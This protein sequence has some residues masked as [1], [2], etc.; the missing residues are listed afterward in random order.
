MDKRIIVISGGSQGLGEAMTKTLCG[1]NHT[2]IILARHEETLKQAKASHGCDYRVCDVSDA[3]QC[4]DAVS[5]IIEAYGRI[6]VLINNAG[7]VMKGELEKASS[8]DIE[9]IL[10]VNTLGTMYLTQAVIPHM[11]KQREGDI[12]SVISTAGLG[13]KKERTLYNTS[14]WA[15]TGFM[16]NLRLDVAPHGM[17]AMAVYPGLM[18]T[19]IFA[20][21]GIKKDD[22][23]DATE[24]DHVAQAVCFMLSQPRDVVIPD[25][26]MHHI[27]H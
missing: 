10:A 16:K 24:V 3:A 1:E 5:S 20:H 17:R 25:L 6:D 27:D 23:E 22:W 21:A 15:I 11:K 19:N 13:A 18:R 7:I 2:V 4:H 12:I 8:E 26:T 14:K 9:K